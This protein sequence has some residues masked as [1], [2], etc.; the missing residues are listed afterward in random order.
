MLKVQLS[1]PELKQELA[2]VQALALDP[3]ATLERLVGNLRG[4]FEAWMNDLMTAE[5][6]IQLG[7]EPYERSTGASNHRNGYRSRQIT[8]KGLGRLE[9]RIPRDREGVFRTGLVPERIQYDPRIEQDLQMLFLGGASTRTVELMSERLFGRRLSSGEVSKANAKLQEPVEAWRNR[10]LDGEKYLYLFVDGTNFSMR[11]GREVEKQ[12]VLVVI[13][14]TENR[15]RQVLALQAGDKES[16]KAWSALF[17]DLVH[18]GLDPSAV[19][20]GI[21]DGLPGLEKAFLATFRKAKVQ[22]CQVHKAMNVLAKVRKKDRTVVADEMRRFFYAGDGLS[23]KRALERFAAKWKAIY[24]D[25]V[26]CLEKDAEALTAFLEFPEAEW[27][28][29]RTTNLIERLHKEFKRR[30]GPMEIVA[31]EASVYRILAFI[32]MKMELAW[33]KAPFRNSGFRKLKP[34]SGYFTHE[35]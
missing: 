28:S 2:A 29:L 17:Q 9:L 14:I 18:R 22:R 26:G 4:S 24:P 11:R 7:R 3:L 15:Q 34:F 1:V 33:R 30:T 16:A 13:G 12:C 31:G 32:A 20:L 10:P 35:S 19:Q 27:V 23:A 25:A 8:M 21:M 6:S 5:L